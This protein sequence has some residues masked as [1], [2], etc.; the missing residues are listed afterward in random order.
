MAETSMTEEQFSALLD[1]MTEWS[2]RINQGWLA[3]DL[4]GKF[5][6]QRWELLKSGG[7]T[8][9]L[10]SQQAGGV[11]LN[12]MQAARFMSCF[13]ELCLDGGLSFALCTHLCSTS[14]PLERFGSPALRERLLPKIIAGE[15]IGAHAI[16]EPESGSDAF[17]MRTEAVAHEGGWLLNGTKIFVSNGPIADHVVVYACTDRSRGTLGDLA[18]FW[19]TSKARVSSSTRQVTRWD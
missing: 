11:G 16:T 17:A 4:Q 19:W 7:L 10:N 9:L 15:L 8:G 12:A 3:D 18:L 13:G 6:Q 2:Q 14:L 5:G 1:G